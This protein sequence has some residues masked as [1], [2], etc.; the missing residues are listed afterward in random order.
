MFINGTFCIYKTEVF[1][2]SNT[3]SNLIL[4]SNSSYAKLCNWNKYLDKTFC[5]NPTKARDCDKA[6]ILHRTSTFNAEC[7]KPLPERNMANRRNN[8]LFLTLFSPLSIK[9]ECG[10]QN[11]TMQ[12][13]SSTKIS[14]IND[15]SVNA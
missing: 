4:Y 14:D 15:C 7:F 5:R 6:Y 2:A 13:N 1:N 3:L 9:I 11:Y 8:D 10:I 12:L